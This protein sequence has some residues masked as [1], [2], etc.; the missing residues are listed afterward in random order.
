MLSRILETSPEGHMAVLSHADTGP[1]H[2]RLYDVI[3][4]LTNCADAAS[5]RPS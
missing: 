1:L 5:A 3:L 2:S 4:V